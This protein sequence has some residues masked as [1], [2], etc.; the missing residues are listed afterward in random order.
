VRTLIAFDC[1][2][3]RPVDEPLFIYIASGAGV[4]PG[5]GFAGVSVCV[6]VCK[7]PYMQDGQKAPQWMLT[8]GQEF[9]SCSSWQQAF[10]RSGWAGLIHL[11]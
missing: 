7:R 5:S 3:M 2:R 11:P 4:G 6:C 8:T 1:L 10:R 9:A